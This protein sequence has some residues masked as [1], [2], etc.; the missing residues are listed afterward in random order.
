MLDRAAMTFENPDYV[1][2]VIHSYRHR[3]GLAPGA[4]EYHGLER[5]LA[6]MP[7]IT[8]PTVT[9]DGLADGNFPATDGTPSAHHFTGLRI[10]RQVPHAGHNL[11][12]EAPIAFAA[13]V[14]EVRD[15]ARAAEVPS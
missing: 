14:H 13:A 15:L 6:T 3:L 2:A 7:P 9:L 4:R 12:A 5:R 10:H 8:V 1:D 11:P